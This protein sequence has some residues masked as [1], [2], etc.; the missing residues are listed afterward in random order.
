MTKR[1]EQPDADAIP[2]LDYPRELYARTFPYRSFRGLLAFLVIACLTVSALW[3][4][5]SASTAPRLFR[6]AFTTA[7]VAMAF[8]TAMVGFRIL[9]DVKDTVRLTTTGIESARKIVPWSK[10]TRLAANG[11]DASRQ[12]QVFYSFR[13]SA[14]VTT[15]RILF[16]SVPIARIEYNELIDVLSR[17]L[18]T[19]YPDLKLGGF[20]QI[21]T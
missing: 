13:L 10:V 18:V 2:M 4:G 21:E 8:A 3:V 9:A 20:F 17:E 5:Y 14:H 15:N 7:G 11:T 1:E 6:A 16:N 12:V 19:D